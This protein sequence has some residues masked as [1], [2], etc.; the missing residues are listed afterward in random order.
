MVVEPVSLEAVLVQVLVT[1]VLIFLRF[2][3]PILLRVLCKISSVCNFWL[4]ELGVCSVSVS[5]P[6]PVSVSIDLTLGRFLAGVSLLFLITDERD[7][8]S[9]SPRDLEALFCACLS[10]TSRQ[11]VDSDPSVLARKWPGGSRPLQCATAEKHTSTVVCWFGCVQILRYIAKRKPSTY[12]APARHLVS[13]S[14]RLCDRL[15][16]TRGPDFET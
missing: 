14:W 11:R 4:D 1:G 3:S 13:Q 5:V 16:C 10:P 12:Q 7:G 2:A 6:L 9:R 8:F 15:L